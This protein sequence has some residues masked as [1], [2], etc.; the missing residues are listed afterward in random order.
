MTLIKK[1]LSSQDG[2][3]ILLAMLLL[4]LCIMVGS[5]IMAAAMSNAGKNKGNR[6]AQQ[7]YFM[8]KSAIE[9]VCGELKNIEYKGEY[10]YSGEKIKCTH[11][12]LDNATDLLH[13]HTDPYYILTYEMQK[14][15][16]SGTFNLPLKFKEDLGDDLN[17]LYAVPFKK[18]PAALGEEVYQRTYTINPSAPSFK[19]ELDGTTLKKKQT[20]PYNFSI[21]VKKPDDTLANDYTVNVKV[22]IIESDLSLKITAEIGGTGSNKGSNKMEALM[23]PTFS[24][25]TVP[26]D[27]DLSPGET[28]IIDYR[29]A[30]PLK[31]TTVK[32]I[33]KA[34]DK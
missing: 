29:S 22:E 31:W 8:V 15:T 1:K 21:Q 12:G 2:A 16:L 32:Y 11:C 17:R 13:N 27:S 10:K 26:T 3:S 34:V 28:A 6:E 14:K 19:F 30:T 5:S 24:T 33:R 20:E 9:L 4:L 7:E 18:A 23:N 25:F